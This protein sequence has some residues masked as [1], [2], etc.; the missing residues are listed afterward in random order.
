[1][2]ECVCVCV[3]VCKGGG[4]AGVCVAWLPSP[5][6]LFRNSS[7]I[8]FTLVSLLKYNKHFLCRMKHGWKS[9]LMSFIIKYFFRWNNVKNF[10]RYLMFLY[11][12]INYLLDFSINLTSNLYK[13]TTLGTTQMWLFWTSGCLI[14]H[15]C[16]KTIN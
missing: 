15:L 3:C 14:W 4:G 6:A 1:M 2:C 10:S 7:I 12:Y 5:L 9:F 8:L 16:K 11:S 13:T